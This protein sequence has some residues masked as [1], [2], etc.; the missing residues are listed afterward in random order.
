MAL[1]PKQM[2]EA[3]LRN[4]E[5]KTGKTLEQWISI[6]KESKLEDKKSI[7]DFLKNTH[8]LGHFQAQKIVE[9]LEGKDAYENTDDFIPKLFNTPDFLS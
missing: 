6:V 9:H 3:I 1:G 7:M 8:G 4:L 5:E 2:G